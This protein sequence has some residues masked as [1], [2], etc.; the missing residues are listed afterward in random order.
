M[1]EEDGVTN[2]FNKEGA[3]DAD[4]D[5]DDDDDDADDA[6]DADDDD[7]DGD[8][9]I[10]TA[11]EEGVTADVRCSCSLI[12]TE[13]TK[14]GEVGVIVDDDVLTQKDEDLPSITQL[15]IQR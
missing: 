3:E 14:A 5:D 11:I 15:V 10:G 7:D 9:E 13:E 1:A 4:A 8:K 12:E 2:E 6:D